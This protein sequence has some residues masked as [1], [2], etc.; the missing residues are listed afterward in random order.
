MIHR[1]LIIQKVKEQKRLHLVT[2]SSCPITLAHSH[3][4]SI[5]LRHHLVKQHQ[6]ERK[7]KREEEVSIKELHLIVIHKI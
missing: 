2:Q 6:P 7:I 1:N 4:T 3:Q 5:E